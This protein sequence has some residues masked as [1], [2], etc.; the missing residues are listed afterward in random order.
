MGAPQE[1]SAQ[2]S[3]SA[4]LNRSRHLRESMATQ[5]EGAPEPNEPSSPSIVVV[6]SAMEEPVGIAVVPV[7]VEKRFEARERKLLVRSWMPNVRSS[8]S[9]GLHVPESSRVSIDVTLRAGLP[10]VEKP[11]RNVV[12]SVAAGVLTLTVEE[13]A[14]K[15]AL[16]SARRAARSPNPMIG[17]SRPP[18]KSS[19]NPR[20]SSTSRKV[21]RRIG[22]LHSEFDL[23]ARALILK[24][25]SNL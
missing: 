15:Y 19:E 5:L 7:C 13:G 22:P 6:K 10:C 16:G 18:R 4:K 20:T 14:Y 2:K 24:L 12:R 21:C 17:V 25:S 1:G 11:P 23:P 8:V 3:R 9:V